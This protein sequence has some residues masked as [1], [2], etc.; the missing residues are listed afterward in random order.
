MIAA[1]DDCVLTDEEMN[2]PIENW[3]NFE[4]PFPVDSKCR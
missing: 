1:L 3:T 2:I 4:D